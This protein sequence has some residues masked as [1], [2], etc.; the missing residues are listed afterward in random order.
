MNTSH[1][2][3]HFHR[4]QPAHLARIP[5]AQEAPTPAGDVAVMVTAIVI[6]LIGVVGMVA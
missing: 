3:R 6:L 4:T 2:D 5:F 1:F